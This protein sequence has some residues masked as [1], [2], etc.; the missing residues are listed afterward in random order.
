MI[1][2]QSPLPAQDGW[3]SRHATLADENL[4]LKSHETPAVWRPYI[5]K[6]LLSV[7][8]DVQP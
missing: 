5:E 1:G 3:Q 8:L 7:Q 4:L 6:L 2:S